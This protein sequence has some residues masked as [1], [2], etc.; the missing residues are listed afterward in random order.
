MLV[1]DEILVINATKINHNYLLLLLNLPCYREMAHYHYKRL[2]N[3]N[4]ILE[5]PIPIPNLDVQNYFS[6]AVD[7]YFYFNN[8]NL[9]INKIIIETEDIL[10]EQGED[11]ANFFLDMKINGIT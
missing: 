5:F 10:K 2:N 3:K 1:S 6:D 11:A 7:K 9:E 4:A 8:K